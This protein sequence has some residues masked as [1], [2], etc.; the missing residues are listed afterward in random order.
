VEEALQRVEKL[1]DEALI[2]GWDQ[3]QIIH[4][5]GTGTL[6]RAIRD[7]LRGF[8]FVRAIRSAPRERGG[9]GVTVVDLG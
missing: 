7:Y 8:P 6:R 5:I 4:G 2:R 9:E 1:V 3:I